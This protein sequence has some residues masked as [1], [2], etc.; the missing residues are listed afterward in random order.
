VR[1]VAVIGCGGS[2][3]TTVSREL[4][5]ILD[6]PVLH[7]DGHYWRDGREAPGEEWARI[8]GELVGGERWIIDGMKLGTLAERLR[9]AD[10]VVFLD[11]P[12]RTCLAG[13]ARRR[14]RHRGRS[15]PELGVYDRVDWAFL[16]WVWRFPRAQ[17][18]RI[19]ELLDAS[20]CRV[21][22]LR[23]HRE[24]RAFLAALPAVA[25]DASAVPTVGAVGTHS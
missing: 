20:S 12:R 13:I 23:R 10:T 21:V 5:R 22:V 7:I 11:L 4:G 18:P 9:R 3:K 17:R 15:R 19:R 6:L 25:G 16:R 24:V 2:G 8:H 1:R 14:L